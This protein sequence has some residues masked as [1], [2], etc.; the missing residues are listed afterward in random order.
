[1]SRCVLIVSH[2]AMVRLPETATVYDVA[3]TR[4]PVQPLRL[5]ATGMIAVTSFPKETLSV[6]DRFPWDKAATPT[7]A[8]IIP[9]APRHRSE[10]C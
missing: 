10:V 4:I 9:G 2:G 3:I 5:P 6:P 8:G 1:M 7:M